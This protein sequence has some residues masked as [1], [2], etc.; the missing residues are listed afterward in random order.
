MLLFDAVVHSVVLA[1]TAEDIAVEGIDSNL[2]PIE[3]YL[4]VV[5]AAVAAMTNTDSNSIVA[6]VS[7][8]MFV[9]AMKM[10]QLLTPPPMVMAVVVVGEIDRIL[11]DSV[12]VAELELRVM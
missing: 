10:D 2:V 9:F 6:K 3:M 8:L 5:A 11:V 4:L 12:L 1:S 7:D